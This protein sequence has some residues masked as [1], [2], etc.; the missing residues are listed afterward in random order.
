MKLAFKIA[1]KYFL[2]KN[3]KHFINIISIISMIT[4]AFG[5]AALFIILS[6]FNG[7]HVLISGVHTTLDAELTIVP[8]QGKTFRVD[9]AFLKK[10][11]TIQ[12]IEFM[13][14]VLEDDAFLNYEGIQRV[15]HIKGVSENYLVQNKLDS[16]VKW[17]KAD[18]KNSLIPKA[19]VGRGIQYDL[20]FSLG[21]DFKALDIW[22]PKRTKKHLQAS[23]QSLNKI[24]IHPTG[25]FELERQYDGTYIFLPLEASKKLFEYENERTSIELKTAKNQ[26]IEDIKDNLQAILGTNYKVCNSDEMHSALYKAIEIE[27]FI[28]YLIF[29]FILLLASL[30]IFLA[31][32]MIVIS[33]KKDISILFAMGATKKF[34]TQI[35]LAEGFLIGM[36]GTSVGLLLGVSFVLL[37]QH[38]GLI[39]MDVQSAIVDAFPVKMEWS[40][41][42]FTGATTLTI[43]LL[44]SIHPA[45]KASNFDLEKL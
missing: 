44:L 13:S 12:G 32:T 30:N 24:K 3:E 36:I 9:D 16:I 31:L 20:G 29:V 17:G 19:V 43:T 37:Q 41:A 45:L 23:E 7:L 14:E 42:V 6:V 4:L 2:S 25:V 1:R 34:I 21:D 5:T 10:I 22:Y 33:K 28:T 8:T 27:R 39:G 26:S 38:F 11:Q 35:F 40:D 18:F 15:V